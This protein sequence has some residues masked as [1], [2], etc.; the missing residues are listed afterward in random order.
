MHNVVEGSL[1]GVIQDPAG[2]EGFKYDGWVGRIKDDS[3]LA[4]LALISDGR[5]MRL[6]D[7]HSLAGGIVYLVYER[8]RD[9]QC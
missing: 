2:D 6:V 7:T 3:Q 5:P 4:E 9:V 1:N 8:V